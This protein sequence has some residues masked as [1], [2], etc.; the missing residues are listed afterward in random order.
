MNKQSPNLIT[1]IVLGTLSALPANT[2]QEQAK[3]VIEANPADFLPL[4]IGNKWT[5][6]HS[7][8]NNYYSWVVPDGPAR[9]LLRAIFEIPRYPYFLD[10]PRN[11]PEPPLDLRLIPEGKLTIEITHTEMIEGFDYFVFSDVGYSW[12][13]VPNLFL[14]GQKVR[15]SDEGVLLFRWNEQDIPLYAFNPQYPNVYSIPEY[16]MLQDKNEPIT[17]R[18]SRQI[19]Y[20]EELGGGLLSGSKPPPSLSQEISALFAVYPEEAMFDPGLG[21]LWFVTGYGLGGY[22]L[23]VLGMAAADF[24]NIIYPVS[25]VIDGQ[26]IAYPYIPFQL[27]AVEPSSWGQLKVRH[28]QGP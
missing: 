16:P 20:A 21:H 3:Q 27:T 8:W 24:T 19:L 15:F 9:V 2:Q 23:W 18:V 28:R 13:P 12:P 6:G 10:A 7:Y 14:A 4:A 26:E 1:L 25:A 22:E 5:Y 11:S 17:L